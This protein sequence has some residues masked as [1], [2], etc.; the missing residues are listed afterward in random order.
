MKPQLNTYGRIRVNANGVAICVTT[1]TDWQTIRNR[2]DLMQARARKLDRYV[3][4]CI[5]H[6]RHTAYTE[7]DTPASRADIYADMTLIEIHVYG[8]M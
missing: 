6:A 3:Q 8:M 4:A 5:A 7:P 1:D 2:L